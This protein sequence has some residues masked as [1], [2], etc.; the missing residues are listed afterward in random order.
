MAKMRHTPEQVINK[1]R[2]AEVTIAEGGT[3]INSEI[4]KVLLDAG[5]SNTCFDKSVAARLGLAVV[6]RG[7]RFTPSVV[8]RDSPRYEGQVIINGH[9]FH[10]ALA[11]EGFLADQ[12]LIALTGRDTLSRGKLEYDGRTGIVTVTSS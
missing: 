8:D 11:G 12:G 1:L 7:P 10:V 2:E 4:G 9:S 3:E 6:E 5:A